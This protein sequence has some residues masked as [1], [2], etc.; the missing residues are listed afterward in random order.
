MTDRQRIELTETKERLGE[1][2]AWLCHVCGRPMTLDSSHFAHV[3]PQDRVH[4]RRYGEEVIHH[5]LNGRLT[6]G[7]RCNAKVQV[8]YSAHPLMADMLANRIREAI[9]KEAT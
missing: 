2:Q 1:E 9:I 8:T 4:I 3:L 5:R 7:L 6:C